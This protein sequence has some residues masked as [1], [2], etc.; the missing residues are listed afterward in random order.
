MPKSVDPRLVSWTNVKSINKVLS[1]PKN[2]QKGSSRG[3]AIFYGSRLNFFT[4]WSSKGM[5]PRRELCDASHGVIISS[6]RANPGVW[7]T[8][9]KYDFYIKFEV[10]YLKFEVKFEGSNKRPQIKAYSAPFLSVF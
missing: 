4:P 10:K 6:V 2:K 9:Q 3:F 1:F 7:H 5:I 8:P